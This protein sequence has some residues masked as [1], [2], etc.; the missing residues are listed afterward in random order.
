MVGARSAL[1]AVLLLSLGFAQLFQLRGNVT[2]HPTSTATAQGTPTPL[3][4]A[5]PRLAR[6]PRRLAQLAAGQF[7]Y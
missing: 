4:T 2:Y 3:P 1:A 6:C 7:P 5:A